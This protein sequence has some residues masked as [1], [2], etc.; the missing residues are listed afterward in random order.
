MTSRKFTC[1][2]F[3][4]DFYPTE[5][6][7]LVVQR[8]MLDVCQRG[9]ISDKPHLLPFSPQQ[10]DLSMSQLKVKNGNFLEV[11]GSLWQV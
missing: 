10:L 5:S 3:G 7:E 8:K 11:C 4:Y 9:W 2:A 1:V 6:G